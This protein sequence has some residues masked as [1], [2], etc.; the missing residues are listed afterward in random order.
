[1]DVGNRSSREADYLQLLRE[2]RAGSRE[3]LGK[4]LEACRRVLL[5][6]ACK[7]LP[8][9]LQAKESCSDLVQ[10][11]FLEAQR[12][13]DQ[14]QGNRPEDLR[15]WLLSILR[16]NFGNLVR[17]YRIN[18]KRQIDREIRLDEE[19]PGPDIERI[20]AAFT[21][22]PAAQAMQQEEAERVHLALARLPE[23]YRLL[24]TLRF[25]KDLTYDEIARRFGC[26]PTTVR[27]ALTRAL[28]LFSLE[29]N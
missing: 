10:D 13:F 23:A 1:M 27:K 8:P 11:T 28:R 12:D 14:F 26:S 2:A 7:L 24:I 15:A 19:R 9:D 4:V 20:L 21:P 17:A 18:K 22:S 25:H 16:N 3:A 29:Y 6:E 5:R